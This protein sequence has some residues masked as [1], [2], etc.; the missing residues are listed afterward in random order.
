MRAVAERAGPSLDPATFKHEGQWG[1]RKTKKSK[2]CRGCQPV[3]IEEWFK[4]SLKIKSPSLI[5]AGSTVEFDANPIPI[6]IAASCPM[7]LLSVVLV[8]GA[9]PWCPAPTG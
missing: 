4:A 3:T 7:C 8:A 2:D 9:I 1:D 6:I 5:K